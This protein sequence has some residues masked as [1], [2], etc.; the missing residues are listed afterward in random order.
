MKKITPK[1]TTDELWKGIIEA[2]FEYFLAFFFPDF[3]DEVDFTKPFEFLDKELQELIPDSESRNRRADLL[4]KVFLK[5][6][7]EKW[8]LVHTEVQGY[9]DTFFD[10]RMYIYNYRS[11]DRFKQEIVAL[12][13][14]TDD[15][16]NFRPNCYERKT[17]NTTIRYDFQMCKLLDYDVESLAKSNNPFASVMFVARSFLNNKAMKTNEDLLS[18]KLQ[19]FRTMFEKGHKKDVIRKIANFIKLYVSFEDKDYFG[20]FETELDKITKFQ[21]T[22]GILELIKQRTLE[23]AQ[24]IGREEGLEEGR[25]EGREVEKR[26]AITNMLAKDFSV[27]MIA[28]ILEISTIEV[29]IIEQEI[30]IKSLFQK[31]LTI[32]AIKKDFKKAEQKI[33]LSENQ[34]KTIQQEIQVKQLLTEGLTTEEIMKKLNLSEDFIL[35]IKK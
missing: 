6:G 13:I 9:V 20:K 18:L 8:I 21:P 11:Y 31:G 25:E 33:L 26:K 35:K 15:N 23:E 5:S 28:G 3:V 2:L 7:S 22:M 24:R 17:W 10:E 16:P 30:L 19:L 14:L 1:V 32:K 27:E 29:Q 12:A 34:L 4:A